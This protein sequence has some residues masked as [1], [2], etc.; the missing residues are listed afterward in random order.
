MA[1]SMA[2]QVHHTP[3]NLTRSATMQSSSPPNGKRVALPEYVNQHDA[4]HHQHGFNVA[5][6]FVW[7]PR[8]QWLLIEF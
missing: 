6:G 4:Y 1:Q 3:I 2:G 5:H 7:C 8:S